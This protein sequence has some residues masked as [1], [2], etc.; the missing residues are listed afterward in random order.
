MKMPTNEKIELCGVVGLPNGGLQEFR[1]SSVPASSHQQAVPAQA[2]LVNASSF[3]TSRP[4]FSFSSGPM[5]GPAPHEVPVFDS[6]SRTVA[7]GLEVQ[8]SGVHPSSLDAGPQPP[9]I[10]DSS[11]EPQGV[12]FSPSAGVRSLTSLQKYSR[13][14]KKTVGSRCATLFTGP[15]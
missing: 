6:T 7:N 4:Q 15:N 2:P 3:G 14:V 12:P 11:Y 8:R 13:R 9:P 5:T 10:V 1:A